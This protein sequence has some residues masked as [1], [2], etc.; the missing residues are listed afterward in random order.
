MTYVSPAC[1]SSNRKYPNGFV[2]AVRLLPNW[3]VMITRAPLIPLPEFVIT[4][5]PT[6]TAAA[7]GELT[8]WETPAEVLALKFV[9]LL[10]VA[11]KVLVPLVVSV[12]IQLPAATVPVQLFTPS[13][14]VTLPVGVPAPGA[15]TATEY[16]TVTAAF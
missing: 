15:V 5:P 3:S 1:T 8:T 4:R 16:V 11:V 2:L 6:S 14:T 13:E 12:I 9:S 7:V 10:Y